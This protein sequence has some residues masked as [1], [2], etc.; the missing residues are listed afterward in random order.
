MSSFDRKPRTEHEEHLLAQAAALLPASARTPTMS[1]DSAMVVREGRGS[2][3]VDVSGNEYIDYLLGSGPMFLGHAHP[4]VVEAAREAVGRGTSYLLPNEPAILLADEIVRAVPCAERVAFGSTGSDAVFFALRL[5]RAYRRRDK[6]LKFEGGYHGQ[7]DHVLMSNQW[8]KEPA[9]FPLAIPNSEGIP[10]SVQQEVLVAPF[11]D[12]DRA[13]ALIEAHADELAAVIVEPMQRTIPPRPGFLEGLRE[14]TRRLE[15]PLIFDEVVTGFRLAYGSAQEYYGVT[16]DLCAMGKSLSGGHPLSVVCGVEELMVFA[17]GVRK[18]TGN[19]VS[20]TGTF[21]GN[22]VSCSVGLAVL[23]ELRREGLYETLFARG[24]RLKDALQ[25]SFDKAGIA[26]RVAGEPPAFQPWFTEEEIV[27]H[28][29]CQRSDPLP[30]HALA[31]AL[32]DR[33]VLKGHE[34]FFVSTVHSDAD[35]DFTIDAIQDAVP[36]IV[37]RTRR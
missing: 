31:Q 6:I 25:A 28:R 36:E 18:I 2:K 17:E 23:E 5:A 26:C 16:P 30:G 15:I 7:G 35:I 9:D 4:A 20:L 32:L 29:S 27:D 37:S 10:A 19:Y 3:I 33:G 14:V 34:K 11:N 21:S 22:P 8:T 1:L 24:Q 13:S 12:I